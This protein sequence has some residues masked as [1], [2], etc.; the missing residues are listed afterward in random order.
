MR[1]ALTHGYADVAQHD[2][3]HLYRG[4]VGVALE[5]IVRRLHG[6]GLGRRK[7]IWWTH[8]AIW[9]L[10][11]SNRVL[12]NGLDMETDLHD[13][14]Q[15]ARGTYEAEEVAWYQ[16]HIKPGDRV[17][18][19]GGNI[20]YFTCL[21]AQW[22]GPRGRVVAYEPDPMLH[23]ISERNLQRNGLD[24]QAEVR[25][26]AVSD[27]AG[28]AQFF[29]AGRNYGNNSLFRDEADSL[30]GTSFEV[31]LVTLD[32]DLADFGEPF[33]F[34][35]MDIQGAESHVLSGMQKMLEERPP[36]LMLLEFWPYGLANMGRE[37]QTMLDQ[38]RSAGYRLSE[39]GSKTP[40]D[41]ADL[42]GRLTPSNR[43]WTSLVCERA[44]A[45]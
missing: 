11:H 38:L 32:E 13:S 33:D 36:R 29:R 24:P 2:P 16:A 31:D 34:V 5:P 21:Y 44:L 40:I 9:R 45:A 8:R 6:H 18:E 15:L 10:T 22:V 41:D 39:L 25:R 20:G 1:L 17:L 30:G 19:L 42:L 14:L 4:A 43:A 26:F 28:R 3:I 35:K 12:I 23:A 27:V 37:P 7:A